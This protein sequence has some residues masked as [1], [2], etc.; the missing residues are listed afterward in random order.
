MA[1]DVIRPT[2]DEGRALGVRLLRTARSGAL[3]SLGPAGG[4]LSSLVSVATDPAGTPLILVSSLS[5][6]T[7]QIIADPRSSLL[8][9]APGR[10][11][12]LA[13]PRISLL[14]RA[15][16][17][18]R[19]SVEGARARQRF[20]ARHPKAELYVDFT[21]FAF[22]ALDVERASL[23]GGFARAYELASDDLILDVTDAAEILAIEEGAVAH[24]NEDHSDAIALYAAALGADGEA[25]PAWRC[26][27]LD[28]DGLDLARG[29]ATLRVPF[30][31]RVTT[32]AALRAT[33]AR[34]AQE[35]RERAAAEASFPAAE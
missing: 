6:H 31:E 27:G 12:P 11:D 20:L 28:P 17:L 23:N 29:D 21:D 26:T 3:A 1:K 15:R 2:D 18:D 32:G 13:H 5:A 30:P 10:G 8:L 9:S 25:G 34:M 35:A 16:R 24:M 33:L 4:P 7:G 14:T 19:E 22:F